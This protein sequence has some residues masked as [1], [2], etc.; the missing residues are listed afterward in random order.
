[1]SDLEQT[2]KMIAKK[3]KQSYGERIKQN[4]SNETAE[5]SGIIDQCDDAQPNHDVNCGDGGVGVD[6][7][8]TSTAY[9]VDKY[10]DKNNDNG[11]GKDTDNDDDDDYE[12]GKLAVEVM[13]ETKASSKSNGKSRS[14]S[15]NKNSS[16]KESF[17]LVANAEPKKAH[18]S[19]KRKRHIIRSDKTN[20]ITV[21]QPWTPP[22]K[23]AKKLSEK[24]T[25]KSFNANK[26]CERL[27]LLV[28]TQR[29]GLHQQQHE[30]EIDSIL[31]KLHENGIIL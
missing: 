9:S 16:K 25:R 2:R 3:F 24:S 30:Q 5:T 15:S 23:R 6:G 27:R 7:G 21:T 19:M 10:N 17:E 26:L 31:R 12:G 22:Q 11:N 18:H 13:S 8:T 28:S 4:S 14:K 20:T 29:A 1:M